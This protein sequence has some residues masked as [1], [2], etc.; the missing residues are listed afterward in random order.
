VTPARVAGVCRREG[1]LRLAGWLVGWLAPSWYNILSVG[2]ISLGEKSQ[3]CPET[4]LLAC[5]KETRS[6]RNP[7]NHLYKVQHFVV[8]IVLRAPYSSSMVLPSVSYILKSSLAGGNQSPINIW[9]QPHPPK[10]Q[11]IATSRI[12]RTGHRVLPIPNKLGISLFL[13]R[14]SSNPRERWRNIPQVTTWQQGHQNT[15]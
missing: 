2:T 13:N 5:T 9:L 4:P 7:E 11:F 3:C 10:H 15:M 12:W 6:T 14:I 8:R 1:G